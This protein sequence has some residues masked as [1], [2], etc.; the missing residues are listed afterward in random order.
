ME[1]G[2][3]CS[4]I[5]IVTQKPAPGL[6]DVNGNILMYCGELISDRLCHI[7]GTFITGEYPAKLKT[8]KCIPCFKNKNSK[9]N[10]RNYR[11]ICL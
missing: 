2:V 1:A 3:S 9:S 4:A 8:S 11:S 7:N 5:D 10:L 6:D